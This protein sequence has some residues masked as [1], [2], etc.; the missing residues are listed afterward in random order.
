MQR[1]FITFIILSVFTLAGWYWL[2]TQLWP[3]PINKKDDQVAEKK[4]DSKKDDTKK[5]DAKKTDAKKDDIKPTPRETR[6]HEIPERFRPSLVILPSGTATG[7]GLVAQL[8]TRQLLPKTEKNVETTLGGDGFHLE[9]ALTSLG[10]GVRR[11]TLN[12]FKGSDYLGRSTDKAMELVQDDPINPSFR[13][14]HYADP[15]GTNPVLGLGERQWAFDGR[16]EL[17]DGSHE[18]RFSTTLP[19][20][21]SLRITKVYRLA[22]KEYHI[23]LLL[24]FK[25]EREPK[26]ADA[27]PI[28]LRY[29]LT[30]AHGLPIE[31]EWYTSTFRNALIG[32]VDARG[33]LWR[34]I[35]DSVRISNHKGGDRVPAG[36]LAGNLLQY[37]G[38]ANQYFAAVIVPDNKQP[39]VKEGGV[40]PNKIL[41]WARPTQESEE[42]RG[43]I[44]HVEG[45]H[46]FFRDHKG[47]E[48]RYHLLAGAKAH[49]EVLKLEAGMHAVVNYHETP[50]G[51]RVAQWLRSGHT[52][53][54]MFDDITV[55]VNSESFEMRPG[56]RVAHR[57]LLY[58]G[59]VK[60]QLLSQFRGDD[61]VEDELVTR[62]TDTLHLRTLTDYRSPGPFGW[63]ASKTMLTTIIIT[64]TKVMHFLLDWLHYFTRSYGLSIVLLT[65][66]VR[67]AL[68]PISR[69][70]ALFSIKMQ[71]LAP[72]MKKLNEKYKDDPTGKSQAV[73]ELYRKHKVHPMAGCLPLFMQMPI[74]LGLYF[75]LQESI[76]FRLAPFLWINNL[77]APDMFLWWGEQIPW[78]TE[79]DSQGGMIYLGPFLNLLPIA[80][81]VLMFLQQKVMTPPPQD[82]QQEM[83][84]KMMKYMTL[85]FGILFYKV[86]AGLCIYFITSSA[87]GLAERKLLP[88]K[89]GPTEA[90]SAAP[91]AEGATPAYQSKKK[92]RKKDRD[93]KKEVELEQQQGAWEKAKAMWS[94]IVKKAEKK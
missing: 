13:M 31:G 5:D 17:E 60:S 7:L 63:F 10:A 15:K 37:A 93:K 19:G 12:R 33:G 16:T 1:N 68:F 76:H 73:M 53:R 92:D 21:D 32:M 85:F 62:Y 48:L 50:G 35:E 4:D 70:Q 40:E 14:H 69:K 64:V 61:G 6:W 65:V 81:M 57:L 55:R 45:D 58:H 59:P 11:V 36:D 52:P 41:A 75:A 87:W 29:Q 56:D 82:E 51:V 88:K 78:F 9:V 2:Q 67:G 77:A 79:I 80:A 86:A 28:P 20:R 3:Q 22:P 83:Q 46:L 84:Q 25:D 26:G 47:L 23:S 34:E 91:A 27:G 30:G 44:V 71:E 54:S 74:F 42:I 94:D 89:P 49:L 39:G 43:T 90:P 24:E 72:E 18:A 38:V 66:M 8:V